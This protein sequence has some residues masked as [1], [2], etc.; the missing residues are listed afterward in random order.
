[1]EVVLKSLPSNAYE[2]TLLGLKDT[3]KLA[4]QISKEI[5]QKGGPF[6]VA[7]YG[8]LGAGKTTFVQF[9]AKALGIKEKILSPTFVIMKTFSLSK[10]TGSFK[11][12]THIDAY[13]L[14]SAKDL[15]A[16]GLK[17]LLKNKENIL[18]IEWPE[19]IERYLPS[20]TVRL[21]FE[22]LG[23]KKRKVI[24]ENSK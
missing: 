19:K 13:R 21:Y 5:L 2:C 12:L 17:D 1:M 7:L 3:Q 22:V 11:F 8:D 10:P 24:I 16:L 6:V 4:C 9:L 20:N 14:K 15:I 18:V 23:E